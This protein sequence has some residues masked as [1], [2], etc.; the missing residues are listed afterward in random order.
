MGL[1]SYTKATVGW[2]LRNQPDN[3]VLLIWFGGVTQIGSL[4]GALIMFPLVNV[5]YLFEGYYENVCKDFAKCDGV[6]PS[7]VTYANVVGYS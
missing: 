5:A 7:G 4:I 3:R 2:I 1:L 6:P